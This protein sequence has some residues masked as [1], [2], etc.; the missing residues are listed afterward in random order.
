MNQ[1]LVKK[2]ATLKLNL[3]VFFMCHKAVL[4]HNF[5]NELVFFGGGLTACKNNRIS[6]HSVPVFVRLSQPVW[7]YPDYSCSVVWSL[8]IYNYTEV[9]NTPPIDQISWSTEAKSSSMFNN[10]YMPTIRVKYPSDDWL[11]FW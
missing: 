2:L 8:V 4:T 6:S 5:R 1:I 7:L 3:R 11:K 9:Y 10:T